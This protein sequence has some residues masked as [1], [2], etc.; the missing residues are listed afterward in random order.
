MPDWKDTRLVVSTN[1]GTG[2]KE[3]AMVDTFAP[4]LALNAEALHA[5]DRSNVGVA[6]TPQTLTFTIT[7][8]AIGDSVARL[9]MLALKGQPFNILLKEKVGD[10]WGLANI[11]MSDCIITSASHTANP[12]GVPTATFSGFSLSAGAETNE[13]VRASVP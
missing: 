8:K 2:D 3:V 9:T 6:F 4:N 11:V 10:D 1:D 12:T 13:G 5:L 7:V